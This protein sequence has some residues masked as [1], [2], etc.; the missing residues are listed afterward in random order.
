M[1]YDA[2]ALDVIGKRATLNFP[3]LLEDQNED[4]GFA[5]APEENPYLGV[6]WDKHARKWKVH[7]HHEKKVHH[8]GYF[9]D[10][11]EAAH[12]Y[13]KKCVEFKGPDAKK[14]NFPHSEN[15]NFEKPAHLKKHKH[16][17]K[18]FLFPKDAADVIPEYLELPKVDEFYS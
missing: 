9:S 11:L 18:A 7:V 16:S 3:E 8:C 4:D 15:I 1:A 5:Q 10:L 2:K 17:T 12:K 14:L 13:D 6:T